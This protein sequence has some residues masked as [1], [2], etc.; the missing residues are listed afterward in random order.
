MSGGVS[1]GCR[2]VTERLRVSPWHAAAHQVR[3]DL[4]EVIADMLTARTTLALPESW[5][6]DF[7]VERAGKWIEERDADSPTLLVTETA[8]GRPVGLV[9]LADA[10]LGESAVDVRIGYLIAEDARG[11]GLATELLVGL[12]DWARSQAPVH[13]LTGGVDPMNRASVRVLEKSGFRRISDEGAST[14]TYQLE[15]KASTK[16]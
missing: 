12:I 11:R 1:D 16:F 10:P 6:G 3:L 7:S 5:R 8:S 9:I 2:F 13:T 14:A 15:V 4:A